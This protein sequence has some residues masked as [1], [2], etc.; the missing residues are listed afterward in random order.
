M[1]NT[2]SEIWRST[3][4]T[5][6]NYINPSSY[7]QDATDKSIDTLLER[8]SQFFEVRIENVSDLKNVAQEQA[9]D[10]LYGVDVI[11]QLAP[12]KDEL[13]KLSSSPNSD[14]S[15]RI[16]DIKKAARA[17][18]E[19]TQTPELKALL[20]KITNAT[21]TDHFLSCRK[22]LNRFL[23][24]NSGVQGSAINMVEQL[25]AKPPAYLK[26]LRDRIEAQKQS[27]D[28]SVLLKDIKYLLRLLQDSHSNIKT[29]PKLNE[30]KKLLKEIKLFLESNS[31]NEIKKALDS[32]KE[33]LDPILEGI[34]L[35]IKERQG[36]L[37]RVLEEIKKE[38]GFQLSSMVGEQLKQPDSS[39]LAL[40]IK[41]RKLLCHNP[42]KEIMADVCQ[43]LTG[44]TDDPLTDL[45]KALAAHSG[46]GWD[47]SITPWAIRASDFID[48]K[49]AS[50]AGDLF[51]VL[52]KTKDFYIHPTTGAI[53]EVT[54]FLEGAIR[55]IVDNSIKYII[56]KVKE[57]AK[58]ELGIGGGA[59]QG[60]AMQGIMAGASNLAAQATSFIGS[61]VARG[62]ANLTD[63]TSFSSFGAKGASNGLIFLLE[64][65][66]EF[67]TNDPSLD[68]GAVRRATLAFERGINS[69]KNATTLSAFVAAL[70][71]LPGVI[72]PHMPPT[73]MNGIEI[74]IPGVNMDFIEEN[75]RLKS[76]MFRTINSRREANDA[77]PAYWQREKQLLLEEVEIFLD[78]S[79]NL[80]VLES[81]C[82]FFGDNS[83]KFEGIN[84]YGAVMKR[85]LANHPLE[86]LEGDAR[87][88]ALSEIKEAFKTEL[89]SLLDERSD[90]WIIFRWLV[91]YLVFPIVSWFISLS[92]SKGVEVINEHLNDFVKN[93][94]FDGSN[95]NYFDPFRAVNQFTI[96]YRSF[97]EEYNRD[98]NVG[99]SMGDYL[100]DRL[101]EN[102]PIRDGESQS[103]IYEKIAG[104]MVDHLPPV[105]LASYVSKAMSD[106]TDFA[107]SDTFENGYNALNTLFMVCKWLF[108][109]VP[110]HIFLAI[111]WVATWIFD[112]IASLL[113][114]FGAKQILRSTSAVEKGVTKLENSFFSSEHNQIIDQLLLDILDEAVLSP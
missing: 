29:H 103:Y 41:V 52:H 99:K 43:Q 9:N 105:D 34:D 109:A 96:R 44:F 48:E 84:G 14:Q 18:H 68:R 24:K 93:Y 21:T 58:E 10:L 20:K 35:V 73:L 110:A 90:M 98:P 54:N 56:E 7:V 67:I 114:N 46:M 64:Q 39:L 59:N 72:G 88:Q 2:L 13:N 74:F 112:K 106:L 3:K 31:D 76:E 89:Y 91:K 19:A 70:K 47:S 65:A 102:H 108:V 60:D 15:Q 45:K 50:E 75:E 113:A 53:A 17:L 77:N 5:A 86:G 104:A 87:E 25:I 111:T 94:K 55:K 83:I 1:T 40:S 11:L 69:L 81:I 71:G 30:Y 4:D 80:N 95:P 42:T 37:I 16:E 36:P 97:V 32:L 66:K 26:L 82:G 63:F 85:I 78:G 12:L 22:E 61:F 79:I 27:F 49:I 101:A 8:L 23:V 107:N 57:V 6:N 33:Q 38:I 62:L 51:K 100:L 92:S 28:A